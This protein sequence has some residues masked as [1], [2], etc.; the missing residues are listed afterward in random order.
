MRPLLRIKDKDILLTLSEVVRWCHSPKDGEI[1]FNICGC[2]LLLLHI[3]AG[4][5]F[6]PPID[7]SLWDNVGDGYKSGWSAAYSTLPVQYTNRLLQT[8]PKVTTE[9]RGASLSSPVS[10]TILKDSL[11]AKLKRKL[12]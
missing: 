9:S 6:Y 1:S 12:E 11:K 10:S 4:S 5:S 8:R 2:I 3:K 7:E